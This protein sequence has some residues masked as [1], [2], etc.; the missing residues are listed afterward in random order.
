MCSKEAV[1]TVTIQGMSESR[2]VTS[3][4]LESFSHHCAK[5]PTASNQT[6]DSVNN[7]LS[8]LLSDLY[9]HVPTSAMEVILA[10]GHHFPD[11]RLCT[12]ALECFFIHNKRARSHRMVG[13]KVSGSLSPT[14]PLVL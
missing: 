8:G 2:V 11:S 5:I 10:Q 4:S 3:K 6:R 14:L 13:N 12:D 1:K 9:E 7:Q